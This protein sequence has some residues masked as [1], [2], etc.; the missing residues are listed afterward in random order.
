[1]KTMLEN[2][3]L[4]HSYEYY[5]LSK[6]TIS[7]KEFDDLYQELKDKYPESEV[8]NQVGNDLKEGFPKGKH[9][10]TMG[11][12]DKI[13]TSDQFKNWVRTKNIEFP[14]VGQLKL[15]GISVELQYQKGL[16]VSALTRGDSIIGDEIYSNVSQMA[17]IPKN[18]DSKF[19]GAVR[20]EVLMGHKIFEE[21]YK[22]KGFANPRNTASGIAKSRYGENCK[23][24]TV[25]CYD[26]FSID[27]KVLFH[28]QKDIINF[29]ADN[30]F[31]PVDSVFH[32]ASEEQVFEFAAYILERRKVINFSIDGI[33]IKENKIDLQDSKKV[34]PDKQRALKWEDVGVETVLRD[35]EWSRSGTVYTPIAIFDS[36]EIEGSIVS[37]ASLANESLIKDLELAIGDTI[38]VSKRNMIIPKIEK[39]LERPENRK[40]IEIPQI[41]EC[42][43]N[44]LVRDEKKLYCSN[45]ECPGLG[46]HRISKWLSV[47][48]VKGFGTEMRNHL[49]ENGF[50]SII[51][52]Y[53]SSKVDY[54]LYKTNLKAN[55]KKAFANL[56]SVKE[57]P[58]SKFF[59]G[60][61]IDGIGESLIKNIIENGNDTPSKIMDSTPLNLFGTPNFSDERITKFI[62]GIKLIREEAEALINLG[63][64]KVT[65]EKPEVV[66]G[67]LDGKSICITGKLEK[68]TRKEL[69]TLIEKSGGHFS[70]SVKKE[71]D[72]L[73]I[74]DRE[75]QSSKAVKARNLEIKMISENEL[76]EMF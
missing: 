24:L 51:D 57:I 14:L 31:L 65:C 5:V 18:I 41:C 22:P 35:I 70:S 27:Q 23:D 32:L 67:R 59:A 34:R 15:D 71:L 63:Y 56:Y 1:M 26:A 30:F 4:R 3:I 39:V 47:L 52:L 64:F 25:I 54:A 76:F 12:Q 45:S 61:D 20:G 53:D 46:E 10:I 16:L 72:Y 49:F 11:S 8:L 36:V 9:L 62:E 13:K 6:P 33:V 17:G 21:R 37:R 55:Y 44:L 58:L 38:L 40:E 50:H 69:I 29:L 2:K 48:D 74:N 19:T 60:F 7:D 73:V 68:G 42:C 43:G 28:S 66:G 75:S